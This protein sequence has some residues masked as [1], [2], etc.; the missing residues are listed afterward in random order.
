MNEIIK[1]IESA[2]TGKL[3]IVHNPKPEPDQSGTPDHLR[4]MF[5]PLKAGDWDLVAPDGA[6]LESFDT[7][8]AA[9]QTAGFY[10]FIFGM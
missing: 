7:E 6:V 3:R 8:W 10:G 5:G 9:R 1:P 2:A 4:E